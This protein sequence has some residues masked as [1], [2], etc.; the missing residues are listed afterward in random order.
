[1]L[2]RTLLAI[3]LVTS[4]L[5]PVG[6]GAGRAASDPVDDLARALELPRLFEVLHAEGLAYGAELEAELF[7]G[8]GG[9]RWKA[10][11]G[12]IHDGPQMQAAALARLRADLADSP[13]S[14][15]RMVAFFEGDLG[16]RIVALELAAR[17]GYLDDTVKEAAEAAH[18]G[19]VARGDPRLALIGRLVTANDLIE[20]NVA[21]ALNGNLA[22][23][24]GMVE[25][26]AVDATLP[27]AEMMADLWSQ[28][29]QIREDTITWL[30]PYLALAYRPLSDDDLE[31]YIDFSETPE[32]Q[33]LNSALFAAFDAVFNGLSR[34]LG[35]AAAQFLQGQDI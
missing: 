22:F 7:P 33:L 26:G 19:M 31:A 25:G 14:V 1:M 16:R 12:A 15:A 24:K 9:A 20:E 13:D 8:A 35:L 17:E 27:D 5:G 21:G 11:V 4:L 32:G 29:P 3:G 28:E 6:M 30:L 18:E 23:Y 2:R 10:I 34:D